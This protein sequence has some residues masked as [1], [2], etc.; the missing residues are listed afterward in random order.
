MERA[1]TVVHFILYMTLTSIDNGSV[2]LEIRHL[3][4]VEAIADEGTMTR[5]A[6]RLHI[7][8][9]ALSHQLSGLEA[10]FGVQLFRRVPR[11]MRLSAA[12]KT[13][14]ETAR[15]VLREVREAEKRLS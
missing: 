10:G 6:A 1:C 8:Q 2:E 7:T 15:P 4:L 13:L 9:S 5:A 11:G 14:L 12:G 3:K